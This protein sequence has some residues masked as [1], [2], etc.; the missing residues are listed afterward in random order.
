MYRYT[1]SANIIKNPDITHTPLHNNLPTPSD[2]AYGTL[3][4]LEILDCDVWGLSELHDWCCSATESDGQR[5]VAGLNYYFGSRETLMG[6]LYSSSTAKL[7]PGSQVSL[8]IHDGIAE[9]GQHL[10]HHFLHL[11]HLILHE[12]NHAVH[13]KL[14]F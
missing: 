7:I 6:V 14:R 11:T 12:L 4:G 5:V 3:F 1:T 2:A 13:H 8:T 10:N 9:V